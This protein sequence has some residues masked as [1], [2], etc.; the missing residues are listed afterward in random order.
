MRTI[1]Y[2]WFAC[3]FVAWLLAGLLLEGWHLER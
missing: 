3:L 1:E 2:E